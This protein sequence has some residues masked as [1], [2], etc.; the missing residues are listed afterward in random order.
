MSGAELEAYIL[1][2][3]RLQRRIAELEHAQEGHEWGAQLFTESTLPQLLLEVETGV[4]LAANP[5]AERFYGYTPPA[6][7]GNALPRI[8]RRNALLDS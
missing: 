4:I 5:A 6:T 2:I 8:E 3:E 1:E 7:G